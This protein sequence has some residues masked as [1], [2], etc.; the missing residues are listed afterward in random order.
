MVHAHSPGS[1]RTQ[2]PATIGRSVPIAKLRRVLALVGLLVV[3]TAAA[4]TA[5]FVISLYDSELRA[6]RNRLEIPAHAIAQGLQQ[7]TGNAD[8]TLRAVQAAINDDVNLDDQGPALRKLL[9]ERSYARL[10]SQKIEIYD[11]AGKR[12]ASSIVDA[13]NP[14][15]V[16]DREFFERQ[17]AA[18]SDQLLVSG[19]VRDSTEG[20]NIIISRPILDRG[21]VVRGVIADYLDADYVQHLFDSLPMLSGSDVVLFTK[22]GRHLLGSPPFARADKLIDVDFS[23]RAPFRALRDSGP[24]GAFMDFRTLAGGIERFV[25]G[26]GDP[27]SPFVVT[28]G[29]DVSAALAHWRRIAAGIVAAAAV[30]IVTV[31]GLFVYILLAL[32][33]NEALLVE[34]SRSEDKFRAFM[35]AL[36]DAVMIIGQSLK[37][38]FANAA[39]EALYGYDPG[40]MTGLPLGRFMAPATRSTDE[41][42]IA[43]ALTDVTL[44]SDIQGL[45]RVALR[46]DGT[47][48][49]VEI[50]ASPFDSTEGRML[51]AVVRDVRA[52]QARDRALTRSRE[53]LAR[54]QRVASVGSFERDLVSGEVEWSEEYLRIW[55][56]AEQPAQ[57]SFGLLM[58]LVHPEDRRKFVE[59]REAIL[60]RRPY[61]MPDFR[62]VRPDGAER[63]LHN[64]Y[65]ADYDADGKLVRL[66][67]TVQDITERKKSEIELRRSR[68][69]LARAQRVAGIGSFE[70]DLITGEIEFS[71]E[72]Y[73]IHGIVRGS[74]QVT[75]EFLHSLVHPED[76]EKMAEFRRT[77][78]AG[79]PTL[80]IDYRIIRPDGVE[81]VLHRECDLLR[82][83]GGTPICLFGTLQDITERKAIELKLQQSRENL[84][85]AQRL[86]GI[87]SFERDLV[88]GERELSDEFKRIWGIDDIQ[89]GRLRDVLTPLIHPEDR[90]K[91][92]EM[93]D[94]AFQNKP[95]PSLDV[96]ITRPNGEERIVHPEFRVIYDESGT[97]IRMFGTVQDVTERKKIELELRR[98]RERL[99]RAHRVAGLGS[100][101]RDLVTGESDWSEE[102]LRIWG[103]AKKPPRG[104]AEFLVPLVHPDDREKFME[105]RN[106]ALGREAPRLLDFRIIRPDG[107]ERILHREYGIQFDENGKAARMFGTVQDVT[108]RRRIEL[109]IRRSRE[110]L[111]RAQRI[112]GIGSFERDVS[113]NQGEWSEEMY[114]I[115]GLD[116]SAP[117]P[118][119][120]ALVKLVHSDDRERFQAHRAAENSGAPPQ[121]LE[122]RVVRP[123]GAT[124][125]VRHESAVVFDGEKRAIRIYGTLQDITEQRLAEHRERELER[126]LLHSQ[127]LEALGTL[128]GGIAH[129]LN[130]TLVPIMALSKVTARRFEAGSLVRTNL[131]TIYEASERARD[132][133]KRVVAFSRKD[134]SEKCDTDIAEIVDEA[135]KL[136]RATIPSSIALDAHIKKVP[137]IPADASQIHQVV[138]NLV[139]NAAQAIGRN[140]GAI[141]VRLDLRPPVL[142]RREICLS[143]SDTGMGMDKLTQQR[144][145]EPFFTTKPV[146]QGTG[147]GLSIVHGIVSGHGGRIE[148]I[149]EPGQGTRFDLYFPVAAAATPSAVTS[150]R[151]A[152]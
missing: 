48:L 147:L 22:D 26:V 136:L 76:R 102:F 96:R 93:R 27:V 129:D 58:R 150:S 90:Q 1:A 35:A 77:A 43:R 122:Y 57:D 119:L 37:V 137:V 45:E 101:E 4:F 87:G 6:I 64:E 49:P 110:N 18:S 95:M 61:L 54:A 128:A 53:N 142:D 100:F 143:V 138:T 130:N 17:L 75:L 36:P 124:R 97:P 40:E 133:V 89:S 23:Q 51:V 12:I 19:L 152:A 72:F 41:Q 38:N 84:T 140:L 105:G 114:R 120:A 141:V 50:S 65:S 146:G 82:D 24:Q 132:L 148:V 13:P 5:F 104:T 85:R 83:E 118:D 123:D 117:V 98:S 134:E 94:A 46:K 115:L 131:E 29:W 52:R 69:N 25:A 81:R 66:F 99:T 144:I 107:E 112:A 121:P 145:F 126:Q 20:R 108:D 3:S 71:D 59:A 16:A 47:E 63:I 149:S 103:I 67:G 28:V 14:P 92:N 60:A 10:G 30:G 15:P 21:G 139:S 7:I 55:G 44:R 33:R 56:V 42:N 73:Q 34:V 68:E 135:L 79:T 9:L 113:A 80:P 125:I 106:A 70:R 32:G 2:S 111:A 151:P 39:A 11:I 88:T 116:R 8:L 78:E 31:G 91:F 109:E 62:I 127:K 74:P 86:A